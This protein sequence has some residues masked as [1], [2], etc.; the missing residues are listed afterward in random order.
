MPTNKKTIDR[1][2][3]EALFTIFHTITDIDPSTVEAGSLKVLEVEDGATVA[4]FD[5]IDRTDP[6]IPPREHIYQLVP[7]DKIQEEL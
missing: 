7:A 3:A 5:T 2:D 1:G 4:I 6:E